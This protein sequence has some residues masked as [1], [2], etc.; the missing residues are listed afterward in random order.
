VDFLNAP[1]SRSLSVTGGMDQRPHWHRARAPQR[2]RPQPLL[3]A[4]RKGLHPWT[5]L[6]GLRIH[7]S[8]LSEV[9][10]GPCMWK[11]QVYFS[12]SL[13]SPLSLSFKGFIYFMYVSTLSLSSDTPEEGIGSHYRWLRC[14]R[15]E[16]NSVFCKNNALKPW[17]I[18]PAPLF[19]FHRC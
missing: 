12:E 8:E 19:S 16:L 6:P 18:S 15:W 2:C 5:V 14:G 9:W 13:F 11:S 17:V 7:S 10:W 1:I 3:G 4:S